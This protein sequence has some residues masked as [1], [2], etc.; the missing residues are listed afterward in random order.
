MNQLASPFAVRIAM[1]IGIFLCILCVSS[2]AYTIMRFRRISREDDYDQTSTGALLSPDGLAFATFQQTIRDLKNK[3]QEMESLARAERMRADASQRL[4][5]T[6][7][8]SLSTPA[9]TLNS[10]GLVQQANSAAR[11]LF[12]HASL[13][14]FNLKTLLDRNRT[15]ED[16]SRSTAIS[17]AVRQALQSS[18]SSKRIEVVCDTRTELGLRLALTVIPGE[19]GTGILLFARQD[20]QGEGA[21]TDEVPPSVENVCSHAPDEG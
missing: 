15:G 8:D 16:G 9:L 10:V 6:L 2:L 19:R 13:I 12:G 7:I 17:D 1:G 3:Q 4:C 14:G 5:R 20:A 21:C 11:D 18:I